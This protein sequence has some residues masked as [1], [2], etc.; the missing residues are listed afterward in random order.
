MFTR[1]PAERDAE[2]DLKVERF[3]QEIPKEVPL[4]QPEAVHRPPANRELQPGRCLVYISKTNSSHP[5]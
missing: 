3:E 1:V 4:D 2:A 5:E